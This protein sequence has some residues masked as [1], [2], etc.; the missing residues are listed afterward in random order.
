[1]GGRGGGAA[2]PAV[3]RAS[4]GARAF[5]IP[6]TRL[7]SGGPGARHL[8]VPE[9]VASGWRL[10]PG[11]EKGCDRPG[12]A[13]RWVARL[14]AA[15]KPLP[16]GEKVPVADGRVGTGELPGRGPS[17][18]G[19]QGGLPAPDRPARL[20]PGGAASVDLPAGERVRAGRGGGPRLPRRRNRRWEDVV[21][22]RQSEAVAITVRCS[23]VS[24]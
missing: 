11:G 18:P 4:A 6:C 3:K 17:P 23:C 7:R 10:L 15:R 9:R 13:Q 2:Y 24:V 21:I 5:C 8:P 22:S 14:R 12:A 1:M 16:G 20:S 19:K